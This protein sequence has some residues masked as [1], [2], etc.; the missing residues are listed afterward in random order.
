MKRTAIYLL[1]SLLS[2]LIAM[3]GFCLVSCTSIY[4]KE[5]EKIPE[6]SYKSDDGGE[7]LYIRTE[8]ELQKEESVPAEPASPELEYAGEFSVAAYCGCEL[9]CGSGNKPQ[10]YFGTPLTPNHTIAADFQL[11][12]PGDRLQIEGICYRV[13][14][15]T[16][17]NS[18]DSL[19]IYFD[20]HSRAIEFGRKTLNVYRICEEEA[21]V[22][23]EPLGR[24]IVT[25]YCGCRLC[26]GIYSENH[27]TFTETKPQANHTVAA[28][29]DIIP[30]NSKL[31][32]N[33]IVYTVEDTG[34]NV[35][36]QRLDIYFDS[37]EEA[38]TY[39]RKEETVYL[40]EKPEQ[41]GG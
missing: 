29:P 12:S 38:V 14:D 31:L 2:V 41:G 21:V 9:C 24:F 15:R 23:G 7:I 35:T 34:K 11:F 32:V 19:L 36:G 10:T 20:S 26:T 3:A 25:G 17:S 16:R 37:H 1:M 18:S 8:Q 28:D 30:L 6:V 27:M 4:G 13:E 40:V 33:G 39:G 5:V 22:E